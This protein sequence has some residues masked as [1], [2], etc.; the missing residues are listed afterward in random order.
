[1]GTGT[2]RLERHTR[3]AQSA[4]WAA[5]IGITL[6]EMQYGIDYV[7]THVAGHV[8]TIVGWLPMISVVRQFW[9]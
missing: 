5:G 9:Q 1:M 7:F 8:G 3:M 4:A 2:K 6:V